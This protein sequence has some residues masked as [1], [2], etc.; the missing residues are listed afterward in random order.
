V[1]N[2][3]VYASVGNAI[4][5]TGSSRNILLRNN[6]LWVDT[7]Y[8]IYVESGSQTEFDSDYNV[9]HLGTDPAARV[10]FWNNVA[11][12]D[13]SAW[14]AASGDDVNSVD[15]NPKFV[16]RDGADDVLGYST[17]GG[18]DYDGGEDD[19]FHL[20]AHSPA[21]DRA[22]EPPAPLLDAEG[23]GRQDDFIT[24][25]LGTGSG[26]V[27]IGA[28]EFAGDSRDTNAPIVVATAP[29]EIHAEGTTGNGFRAFMVLF[30][31][32]LHSIDAVAPANYELLLD[33]DESGDFDGADTSFDLIPAYVVGST[34]VV[35]FVTSGVLPEGLYQFTIQGAGVHDLAGNALD[36]DYDTLSGG[37]YVRVF[38][39]MNP[40]FAIGSAQWLT[41]GGGGMQIQFAV[42]PGFDYYVD[43]RDSLTEL[44]DWQ[45]LPGGPHNTGLVED[46]PPPEVTRRFYRVRRSPQ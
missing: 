46:Y 19:N 39:I 12:N 1:V 35:M 45:P 42:Q 26:I 41:S 34:Q 38:S 16:D 4:A 9:F 7:G 17:A 22:D 6:I 20:V 24:A 31:E 40:G 44:P 3:T 18:Q 29:T 8:D 11:Q 36:G 30:S 43:Y 13:L 14:Q 5:V 21:I 28:Y 27:E 32:M 2:N 10:G 23:N 37:D 33:S 15:G 25:N